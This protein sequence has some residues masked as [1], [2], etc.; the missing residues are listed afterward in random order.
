[1]PHREGRR[2]DIWREYDGGIAIRQF[3]RTEEREYRIP[4]RG[5]VTYEQ[6]M[7]CY[8]IHA[9]SQTIGFADGWA[10]RAERRAERCDAVFSAAT[11]PDLCAG[12]DC[13]PTAVALLGKPYI[14]TYL[15][16]VLGEGA[17]AIADR[18]E[19]TRETVMQ[20]VSD[21][22]TGAR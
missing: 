9:P 18:L 4:R 13:V 5:L 21:V 17:S 14:A 16:A 19:I 22:T 2:G 7:Y 15:L 20:Y 8:R 3:T 6:T 12:P 1:M 11:V 10:K